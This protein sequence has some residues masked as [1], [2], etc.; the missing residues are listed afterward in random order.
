M[1]WQQGR[2]SRNVEDRR[3]SGGR[4][5]GRIAVGGGGLVLLIGVAIVMALMG[6][7]PTALLEAAAGSGG[8]STP[9]APSAPNPGEDE[10]ADFVSVVLADTEDTW[11]GLLQ[12]RGV[13]YQ[14][15]TLVLFRDQ[16]RSACGLNSAAVGPFYCPGDRQVYIDLSF[17]EE[18]DRR[19]GAP[20]D[21][22]QAYVI[23]HEVGHHLQTHLGISQRIRAQRR[24]AS[25]VESNNL[26][27]RQE[28]QADCF[29]GVWAHHANRQRQVLE[30][31]DLEEGLRAAAAIGDD[32]L[33]RRAGA[34]VAPES[35]THG[36]SEQRVRWFR[37]GFQ[38]GNMDVC[39]TFQA[40]QL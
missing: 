40:A 11:A 25:E 14:A 20:G 9:S 24:R 16:V 13:A 32:T 35:W 28:L 27:V 17:F 37:A 21:F 3:G 5:R 30:P 33:Q 23:A 8:P 12:Q 2:R 39:D 4:G 7:D 22:A 18:L 31:G 36:S 19:F 1:R 6:K 15:P 26:S 29:A 34:R 38:S 10:L